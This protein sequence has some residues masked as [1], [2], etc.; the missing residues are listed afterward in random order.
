VAERR[1]VRIKQGGREQRRG[2]EGGERRDAARSQKLSKVSACGYRP[3][4]H[5]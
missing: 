4:Y 3:K 2:E 5:A 1:E